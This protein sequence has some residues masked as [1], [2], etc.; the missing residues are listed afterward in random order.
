VTGHTTNCAELR[1]AEMMRKPNWKRASAARGFGLSVTGFST[2]RQTMCR[3]RWAN[4]SFPLTP[5]LSLG[6]RENR[7]LV[8]LQISRVRALG[9]GRF[10][11]WSAI[12]R[13]GMRRT[14]LK[15]FPNGIPD[16]LA[17]ASET[18][19]PKSQHFD[20]ASFQ[21]IVAF[22]I[23]ASVHWKAVARAVEFE[24]ESRLQT[25]KVQNVRTERILPAKFVSR[26]ASVPQPSPEKFFGP[27]VMLPHSSGNA[28]DFWRG[29]GGRLSE[30]R[31]RSQ[32]L[33]FEFVPEQAESS[34]LP[35]GEGKGEGGQRVAFPTGSPSRPA[36]S[37]KNLKNL[38]RVFLRKKP[39]ANH[40][41]P[42]QPKKIERTPTRP[43]NHE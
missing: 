29:H 15:R 7:S 11:N 34:P 42:N 19:V 38:P 43:L 36:V 33:A 32:V 14:L 25:E 20:S 24:V 22:G 3:C 5:A 4:A 37:V 6:E 9:T 23:S 39:G 41:K 26:E 27:S 18:R 1:K 2:P 8:E 13:Q 31:C 21:P 28:S 16:F 40:Q 12:A 10:A 35:K 17:L 30:Q